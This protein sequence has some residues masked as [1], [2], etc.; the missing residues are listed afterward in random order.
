MA[1]FWGMAGDTHPPPPRG[2]WTHNAPNLWRI[3]NMNPHRH[4]R[5][6]YIFK[7]PP[8]P[9]RYT[10]VHW[11]HP[12]PICARR[13]ACG[14]CIPAP[15]ATA[16]HSVHENR[17][18]IA[19]PY[20]PSRP[21]AHTQPNPNS[22]TPPPPKPPTAPRQGLHRTQPRAFKRQH[23][24]PKPAPRRWSRGGSSTAPPQRPPQRVPDGPNVRE[25]VPKS[26]RRYA[27]APPL[28]GRPCAGPSSHGPCRGGAPQCIC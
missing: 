12:V 10:P 15:Q 17:L 11:M 3:E 14:R 21:P 5:P 19:R 6:H 20:P 27:K 16:T 28:R 8:P 1:L 13:A 22:P 7:R 9:P 26:Y 18:E 2:V 24:T 23:Q 25:V 4:P